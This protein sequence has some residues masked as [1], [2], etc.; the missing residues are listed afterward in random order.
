VTVIGG[1][2]ADI[3]VQQPAGTTLVDNVSSV[4]FGSV[5]VDGGTN[6]LTFTIKNIGHSTLTSI[7]ASITGTNASEFTLSTVPT[8]LGLD[9]SAT[10]TVTFNP[11]AYGLRSAVLNI[12]SNDPDESPF[13][14]ALSGSG[15]V[16][17][18]LA[19]YQSASIVVGQAD[20]DDQVTIPST[21]VTRYPAGCAV[22][23]SGRLA[24]CD[25]QSHC[26]RIWDSVPTVNG[27]A[28]DITL[29]DVG[30]P[31]VGPTRFNFP[32]G[33]AWSGNDLLVCDAGNNRVLRF[34][35]PTTSGQAAANVIGQTNFTNSGAAVSSSRLEFPTACAVYGAILL[36][37]DTYNNRVL[38][39]NTVPTTNGVAA[40]VVIGQSGFTS[41]VTGSAANR[42][43]FPAGIAVSSTTGQLYVADDVNNRVSIFG[44]VPSANNANAFR[45]IGL[46][47]FGN[48]T[49]GASN[50]TLNRPKGVAV[51][52]A[53][54][55]AVT[56]S[57]AVKVWYEEPTV[58]GAAAH[59]ILGQADFDTSLNWGNVGGTPDAKGFLSPRGLQWDGNDLLVSDPDGRRT[60]IFKP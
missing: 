9:V 28:C 49:P 11:A 1:N 58:N 41:K 44:T 24:I 42:F 38:R 30:S 56:E 18:G 3:V 10:F 53:G 22:S 47:A 60:L 29:G 40:N 37:S 19:T 26:V 25:P 8:S 12:T 5:V 32:Y 16:A 27:K 13:T 7:A 51:S 46:P 48:V 2:A 57:R 4:N 21:S 31:G 35:N 23:S 6:V 39:W 54:F 55:V 36:V 52:S 50:T 20:F 33:V 45:V 59:A 43:Y 34:V 14:I 15:T 17:G